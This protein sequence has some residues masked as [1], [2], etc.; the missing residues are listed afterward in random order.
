MAPIQGQ[1]VKRRIA[2][3][4]AAISARPFS[5]CVVDA[6]RESNTVGKVVSTQRVPYLLGRIQLRRIGRQRHERYV[7]WQLEFFA[8]AGGGP[9]QYHDDELIT[10]GPANLRQKGGHVLRVHLL[11][12]H[13]IQAAIPGPDCGI[14]VP[15]LSDQGQVHYRPLWCGCP[16]GSRV[17]HS[18]K[19]SLILEHRANR[20]PVNILLDG[21]SGW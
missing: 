17:T 21:V 7:L 8:S 2:F 1:L 14:L 4:L 20:Q 9:I 12:G 13:K 3:L 6:F 18:S 5:A 11:G 19:A 16:A 15:E 10:V